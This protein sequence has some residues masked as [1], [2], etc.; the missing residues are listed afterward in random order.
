MSLADFR[1]RFRGL[2]VAVLLCAPLAGCFQPM[3]GGPA[4][5]AL[6]QDLRAIKVEPIPERIGHYLA[7]ELTSR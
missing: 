1:S 2:T 3:Y 4:G 6:V 5:Q 7:N